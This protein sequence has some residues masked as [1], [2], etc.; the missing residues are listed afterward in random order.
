MSRE[1]GSV[2]VVILHPLYSECVYKI[3]YE[4]L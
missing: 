1:F 2:L 3:Q 4:C